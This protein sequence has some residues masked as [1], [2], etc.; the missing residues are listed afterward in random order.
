MDTRH[1]QT[2]RSSQS[3]NDVSKDYVFRSY[4]E[5]LSRLAQERPSD[6]AL[7]VVNA[8]GETTLDYATLERR[9]RAL[10]SELQQRFPAG[11]RALILLDNDEHYVVAF[12]ACLYA[13]V[14]AVPVFP[15]ESA[16]QQHLARLLAIAADSQAACVL[17]STTIIDVVASASEGF[18]STELIPV[19]S[20][21][22]SHA[23]HWV[24][25]HPKRGDIAFLQYTSG[26]TATPKGV[27]VSHGNLMANERAIETGFSIGA[28]D[29]FVSWLPLYHDMGLIGG[30]LQ[31]IY[32]GIPAVLM[33]PTFFLQ[34][35]VRWLEAIS[36][37]R[38]TV[39]GGPDF[40]YRL[41]LERI[42]DE[43]IEALDLSSWRVAFSGAEPV[44]HDTLTGFIERFRPAGFAADTAAPCY[45]LAE[46]TLLVSCNP[47]G[48]GV[49]G[50]VFSQQS[51]AEG[52]AVSAVEGNTLVGCGTPEPGHATDI[53]DPEGL[54][55]LPEGDVGEIWVN[56]PSVAHG[57]WRNPEATAN[58][59]VTRDGVSW[60]RTDD[61][62]AQN[63]DAR[64]DRW[65]RTGDLG[66][67][68]EGQ[69]YIAG[70][71]KDLIILRGHNVYPQ[72]I[73]SAIEA[74]VEAVRKG[75][76]ATF[77]VTTPGG[78]EGIGVAAE[79]SRGMQKLVP[80]EKL[81]EALSETVGSTCHEPLSV[82]LLL[83]PGG[84]PKTSSGK[85][86]RS[87][88]R[89]GWEAG[90]LD[91]YAIYA[92]GRFVSGGDDEDAS[93]GESS[94]STAEAG[95]ETEQTLATL[96]RQVLGNNKETPLGS[97][98]HFFASGGNSLAAVQLASRISD[99]WAI[100]FPTRSVMEKPRFSDVVDEVERRL[101]NPLA[102]HQGG[103]QNPLMPIPRL[104]ELPLAPVQRR[105]WLV[106]RLA[107]QAGDRE[108]AAYN[109]PAL[110]S[111]KG[112]LNIEVLERTV[113]AIVARHEAL[114]THYPE[115]ES[116]EPIAVIEDQRNIEL[117]VLD[118]SDLSER[119]QQ[120][121]LQ[122]T[123]TEYANTPFDLVTGPL[124]K[125]GLLRFGAQEHALVLVIHHIVF[126]GWSTSVFIREFASLYGE[127][128][129]GKES[130][131]PKLG[132]QYVDYAAWHEKALSGE[133]FE[134]SATFWR[135]YLSDAPPLSTLPGDFA[136][137][138]QVS[139]AGRAL[140]MTLSSDLSQ[141]L[142]KLAAQHGTTLFTLLLA[143]FQL[144]M[145]RQTRQH[146]LIVGTDV[147]G[148]SHPDVEPL[149]GFFVNVIPLRSRLSDGQ[150]D[151][152]HWL[153]HVQTSVLDAFD[154]QNVPFDRIV[155]LSGIGRERD[156]TPL[157]QT[158]F[159]LQNMPTER[160]SL[161]GL[162][163]EVMP[164]PRQES[165]FDMAVFVDES[166]TGLS[167]EWVYATALYRRE[168]I[169]HLT[170]AWQ[171]LLAQIVEAPSTPVEEFRLPLMEKHAMQNKLSKGSKL[172]KL[173]SL[174]SQ[175]GARPS[176]NS[177][178][179]VR[180][181]LLDEKRVFPLMIEATDPDLDAVAWATSQRDFI[182]QHLRTHA[183]ILFRNFGLTTLQEFEA[184]AEAIQPGL[185][186][187]YGDLPKKEGG[188][189]TYRSTP[190]PE[191]QMILY[192][193]ESSHL[194]R[195]PR[196]QLFFCEFP[197]PVG[198]ATPIVDCREML[199]Q[200]PADVVEEFERKGLLYVRTFTRNLDVSWRDFFKT[201]SKEEVEARLKEA[202][203]EWQWLGDDELQTRTRCPA[204]VTHP[205]TGD[206]VFFNQVQLH[207]VSCLEQDVKEDLL[208]MVG[209]ER[210]PRN[211]YF[212]DG[213]VISD[214]MMKVVGE[215]Y[216]A[217]AVRFDWRRGDVVM[218]DN[219]LAAH[220]R[221]PYEGPRKI[222]VAMGDIYER[223][224]LEE[225]QGAS[226]D[227]ELVDQ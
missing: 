140:S 182:E 40:A 32:R 49:V 53:V 132:I 141:A 190:Y 122:D 28:D 116:G 199:R 185:Y 29:V 125:A 174:K 147:A 205:V 223:S 220:A 76:I 106:D 178:S 144:L 16:K 146:D 25:H 175:P 133:A 138:S 70:R 117:P 167:V 156:R 123:F 162:E 37:H 214:E 217:C 211:V 227:A 79:V 11:E 212:G 101:A 36:R 39:S 104:A 108:R 176:T 201:D 50:T 84:L 152:G 12:F 75:R 92:F 142:N 193:N 66:F 218:V 111:L 24:E 7:I 73:E 34:R 56:G 22:E 45:G 145:H 139:H 202:G 60:Q 222:V 110:F 151:F 124:I 91:A 20:V 166:D 173:G 88:C 57:Y 67:L 121:Y 224:A 164:Q 119:E 192:H 44:R 143:S 102:S 97:N 129:E 17:T 68:H 38:G 128:L 107:S 93:S 8:Q 96:W 209:Q 59:F 63:H 118:C 226:A 51:L 54:H 184:F 207:H 194:E 55:S 98:A 208:G 188:R 126:D 13:G 52:K 203:I 74:E 225:A 195:W 105:L 169:E 61:N 215:A 1:A 137:P 187:N 155:E 100:D 94:Q 189:N 198:G 69:L 112:E 109:L 30:L 191:R 90:S 62:D 72:D 159:V 71:I 77:A 27:M 81:V 95:S 3:H 65:L 154:H 115:S 134:Q 165:K 204:V 216:E 64:D 136:R 196:K 46:A 85:L 135:R 19:D 83:N 130:G 47:R 161:P 148:R 213:S 42:R 197:S 127:L 150:I 168:T 186:G 87:A 131:L 170:G 206:R 149:I 43:Q 89:Q 21:D 103:F 23:E 219:M 48:T 26:S 120:R 160:F 80:A 172:N 99:H 181:A 35:P 179:P 157:I 86:Q 180:T 2:T 41:C 4:V 113:N 31:P 200:L 18:G 10:A 114:R 33:S 78:A 14:V 82:V 163:V 153:E 171:S 221:D 58:T 210:L 6:R 9:S 15:P 177:D 5:H 158:L 183:G